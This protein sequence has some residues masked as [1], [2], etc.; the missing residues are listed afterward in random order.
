[1]LL[2][3]GTLQATGSGSITEGIG[4]ARI[5][6][7]LALARIDD[8]IHVEDAET[9]RFVYRLLN[10]EGLFLG[11][12]S[13]INV[14]AAVRVARDLGPGHTVVTVLCDGGATINHGS[15]TASGL[16]MKG[17]PL[18]RRHLHALRFNWEVSLSPERTKLAIV[19][20][21]I[22]VGAGPIGLFQVFE[23]DSWDCARKSSIRCQDRRPVHRALSGKA[24]LRHPRRAR[25]HGARAHRAP[26]RADPTL[27]GR[28]H[29]GQE[30]TRVQPRADG[31]FD[32]ET[33]RGARFDAGSVIIAAGVGAFQS[34]RLAVSGAEPHEGSRVHYR[35]KDQELF[36]GAISSS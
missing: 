4:I 9:V 30:V 17:L 2:R 12:T 23:W 14:A 15:I 25:M 20:D 1:M 7:N 10:E 27:R 13:G 32:V 29:L 5:T 36:R 28:V 11:S 24:Y 19:T 33:S 22:I 3:H 6:E 34:R 31:R 21:A 35:V 8:A 26:R 16:Q 18:P